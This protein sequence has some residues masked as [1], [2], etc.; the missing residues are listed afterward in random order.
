[1]LQ[2]KY[3][4]KKILLNSIAGI[5]LI[6]LCI[7]FSSCAKDY[8]KIPL[9]QE[10]SIDLTFDSHDSAGTYAIEFLNTVYND[11]LFSG[12]N[13]VG[14]DYLDAA[15]DDAISSYNGLSA[16]EQIATGAYTATQPNSDDIW[17][18]SYKAIRAATIFIV[19]IDRVP[20]IEKLPD[21]R[22]ARSAYKAEARFLRAWTYFELIRRYGGVPLLGNTVYEITD[23]VELP[24]ASFQ[25]C[26]DYVVSELDAAKDSLRTQPQV[27]STNYG[28]IT[29]GAAMALKA[30]VLLYAASPLF[31]GGNIDDGDSLTG[32]ADYDKNRWKLAKDAAQAVINLGTYALM[33]NYSDVFTTQAEPIAGNTETIFWRQN[34]NNTSVETVNG[35]IGYTSAGGSGRTSPTQNLVDA[36]PMNNGLAITDVNSGYD[37]A[38]PYTN[39][40]PRLSATVFYNGMLW[41]NRAIET[42]DGGLDKPGGTL[43]QTKTAYYMRKF[44][45][46]F[47]SVSGSP[48]YSNTN[49]DW[50]YLRYADVLLEYA[51]AANEYEGPTS[52]VYN[53]LYSLRQRAGITAGDNQSYGLQ[54]GMNQDQMR[55]AIRNER[56]IEMAFE[57]QRY[58]DIRRWKIAD[59]LYAKPLR[60]MDI[61]QS[62]NGQLFYNEIQVLTPSFSSPKM[63]FYPIP[64][65]E[66]VKDENMKQNPGW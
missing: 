23:N 9:G 7:G 43:Q 33:P 63:Y 16:V 62:S 40:D 57:E 14:G 48:V 64:Y 20:I 1:M 31:N 56:R 41:L 50:I 2:N 34:G 65:T 61:Q 39:R 6:G 36:F 58:W 30:K 29:Q 42:F 26:I 11:A 25:R 46:N 54:Q 22:S 24:R 21:G 32:Y 59:S 3:S 37:E 45:G 15:S 35:P 12:H 66:F 27:N 49:H 38:N 44:M 8:E 10:Q 18:Q 28:R 47:E 51:E 55:E 19:N 4:T 60:G 53:V 17:T 52:D 5:L 13:R